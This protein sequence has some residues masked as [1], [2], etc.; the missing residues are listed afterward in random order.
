M[1]E[2]NQPLL[3]AS[4]ANRPERTFAQQVVA[5]GFRPLLVKLSIGYILLIC[6]VALFVPFIANGEPYTM[7]I[8]GGSG[9]PAV[10]VFP[11]FRDLTSV[12][13]ILVVVAAGLAGYMVIHFLTRNEKLLRRVS[14]RRSWFLILTAAATVGAILIV[15]LHQNRLDAL[16]YRDMAASG[17][18]SGAIFA[19][20]R[21]GYADEEPL[22]ADLINQMP[23]SRHLLGTD[24]AGRDILSRLLWS[25][26]IAMGV[27]FVSQIIALTIGVLVGAL[28]GYFGGIVDILGM[29]LVEIVE[30][31]PTL[32]LILIFI[33]SYGRD[34]FMIM[35]IIGVV[36]W[37]G[38]TRLLRGEFLRIRHI[39]YV[40]AA[41]AGGVPLWRILFKHI[42][43]NGLTPVLV[44]AS[45]G[46]AAAV[47]IESVLSYLGVGVAPPTPSWGDM[48]NAAG[49]PA[50][51]FHWWQALFPGFLLFLTILTFIKIGESLRDAIDPTTL[52]RG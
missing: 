25:A 6:M 37:T 11:L 32:I 52:E 19:P 48:L 35:V 24:T 30:S 23:N 12:D 38:Y 31:T 13:L 20:I 7:V 27:G 26:R 28:A 29:R 21:W 50:V 22:S 10:R 8:P 39:D 15:A 4:I 3:D 42:L 14:R 34:I 16:D 36:G 17:Q 2:I 5:R 49:N 41:R 18:V 9:Q 43:P 33:A 45:F 47:S 40:T 46:F 44:S 1:T 51:V